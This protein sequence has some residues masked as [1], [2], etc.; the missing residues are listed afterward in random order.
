[1]KTGAKYC[2]DRQVDAVSVCL[3]HHLHAAVA[4]Q[5]LHAGKHLLLEKP[6]A[7]QLAEARRIVDAAHSSPCV[8]MVEMTHRFFPPV[9]A[10][11]V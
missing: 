10:G 2:H 9:Q 11:R 1:M 3:P 7:S 4:I 8:A 6:L 5:S